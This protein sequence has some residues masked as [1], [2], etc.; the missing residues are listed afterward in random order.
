[1]G[2]V[3]ADATSRAA[4]EDLLN[5]QK[6]VARQVLEQHVDKV[7][8]LRDALLERHELVADEI[9]EVLGS[10]VIDIRVTA[11]DTTG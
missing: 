3:I 6:Q 4:V 8:A 7:E 11:D 5:T 10:D 2:R 1:V 9:L